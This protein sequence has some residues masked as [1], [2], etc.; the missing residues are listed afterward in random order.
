MMLA[1]IVVLIS[2]DVNSFID[3]TK[4]IFEDIDVPYALEIP[5]ALWK[6]LSEDMSPA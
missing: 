5:A 6:S 3:L 2:T 1:V 4:R